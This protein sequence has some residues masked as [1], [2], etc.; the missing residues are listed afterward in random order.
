[1]LIDDKKTKRYEIQKSYGPNGSILLKVIRYYTYNWALSD[2]F[3]HDEI[4]NIG[5]LAAAVNLSVQDLINILYKSFY[6]EAY[7]SKKYPSIKFK[8]LN[9]AEEAKEW[10][11]S[12]LLMHTMVRT[13]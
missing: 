2:G 6:G 10:L 12:L 11:E 1:M 7:N 9:N 13:E 8:R 5:Q 4:I 3:E